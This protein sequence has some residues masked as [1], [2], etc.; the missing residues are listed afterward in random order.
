MDNSI[1]GFCNRPDVVR[2]KRLSLVI[3][4]RFAES[5]GDRSHIE[6]RKSPSESVKHAFEQIEEGATR[7]F[8]FCFFLDTTN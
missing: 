4:E 6:A 5:I 2:P 8:F 1:G 3:G 7:C